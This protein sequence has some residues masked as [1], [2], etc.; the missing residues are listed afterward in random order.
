MPFLFER[1]APVRTADGRVEA[2]D[3]PAA[4]AAQVQRIVA[5]RTVL[6]G[7]SEAVVPWGLPNA[8]ELGHHSETALTQYAEQARRLIARHE[9]RL[10]ELRVSVEPQQDV[11]N[12]Y[13]LVVSGTLAAMPCEFSIAL[14]G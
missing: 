10:T 9:P 8:V 12:P 6:Q 2:F 4:V 1:L 3:E 5:T 7:A 11:L 13:L 14:A